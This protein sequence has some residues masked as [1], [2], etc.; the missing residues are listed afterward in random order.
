MNAEFDIRRKAFKRSVSVLALPDHV[1]LWKEKSLEIFTVKHDEAVTLL[2]TLDEAAKKQETALG[3]LIDEKDC[4]ETE[5]EDAAFMAAQ[6]LVLWF[7]DNAQESQV[8]EVD[9]SKSAWKGLRDQQLLSRFQL[10]IDHANAITGGSQDAAA[11]KYG[12]VPAAVMLTKERR[13][14]DAIVNASGVAPDVRK[15]LTKGFRP[16]FTL[17]EKKFGELDALIIQFG[18]TPAGKSMIAARED[19][20]VQKRATTARPRCPREPC[21]NNCGFYR[22]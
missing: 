18:T 1:V 6:A 21:R 10:V 5:F 19:A 16:A 12:I 15:D 4:E 14:Y 7:S 17:L 22:K 11:A 13:D 20:R 2:A 3:G 8:R 9:L